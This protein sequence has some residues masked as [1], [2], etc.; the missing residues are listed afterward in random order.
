VNISP[1]GF[2]IKQNPEG[3]VPD[4]YTKIEGSRR[5][6]STGFGADYSELIDSSLH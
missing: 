1:I 2:E 3:D 6:L 4:G 5:M